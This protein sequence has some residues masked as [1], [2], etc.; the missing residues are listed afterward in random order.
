MFYLIAGGAGFLGSHLCERLL[1]SGHRV[2]CLDNFLTGRKKNIEHL[3]KEKNFLFT[4]LDITQP[5]PEEITSTKIDGIFHLASPASPNKNSPKSYMHFPLETML[6]NSLG[7]YNLLNLTK[8]HQAK[9][10]FASSS[11]IYGE[12]LIH[13]QTENYFGN[14]N[15]NGP[16]SCYD[17]GKRFGE[18]ISFTYLRKDSLDVRIVRIF[19]T[20][21]PRM[22]PEDGRVV[23][24]FIVAGLL[25]KPLV[26]YGKGSQTRSFCYVDDLVSGLIL[27]MEK[28][29]TK[30]E[31]FN[32]GNDEEYSVKEMAH[33]VREVMGK[34][35]AIAYSS[36]P[37]DD[38]SR[39]K[40]NLE[41]ARRILGYNP[42]V[43]ILDGLLK[44]IEYF[45]EELT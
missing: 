29:K 14:V 18:A 5:F 4:K 13:P 27:A 38:P 12:P 30:G 32:L 19:N 35:L 22:D 25:N 17:E 15:P 33:L 45:K 39:R 20:Y 9:F 2:W 40:P 23:S 36:L 26:L 1:R 41:K 42:K 6:V 31:V 8:K 24:N 28:S 37:P 10:L 21:G 11:E 44:T 16:R 7:T 43:K 34:K 3:L